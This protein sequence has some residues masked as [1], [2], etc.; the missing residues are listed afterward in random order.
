MS[1]KI[2][3]NCGESYID[4][5]GSIKNKKA[6]INPQNNKDKCFQHVGT[7]ILN[8]EKIGKQ[9][10]LAVNKL[11]AFLRRITPKANGG[12]YCLNCFH[13]FLTKKQTSITWIS[14]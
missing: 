5:P 13:Y 11:S 9:H 7:V 2:S 4:S 1:Y 3:L 12:F 10:Y 6:A 8:H 14:V